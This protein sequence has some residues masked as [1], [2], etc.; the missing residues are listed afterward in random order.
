[1]FHV[2]SVT[3]QFNVIFLTVTLL[4]KSKLPMDRLKH[5]CTL[6]KP[7]TNP[8][9]MNNCNLLLLLLVLQLSIRVTLRKKSLKRLLFLIITVG[10]HKIPALCHK[11]KCSHHYYVFILVML[12][13]N[14][15]HVALILFHICRYSKRRK[16]E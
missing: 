3:C 1:M 9:C 11:C 14:V 7:A 2:R 5:H 10:P 12:P 4:W 15:S 6:N 16:K 8:I 13:E